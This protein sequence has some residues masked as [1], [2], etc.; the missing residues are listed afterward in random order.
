M[1][2][3]RNSRLIVALAILG[4]G[5]ATIGPLGPT[6]PVLAARTQANPGCNLIV[7]SITGDVSAFSVT[8]SGTLSLQI[9]SL[10]SSGMQSITVGSATNAT[11]VV[12]AFTVGTNDPVAVT[13]SKIDLSQ[14]ASFTLTARDVVGH[15]ITITGTVDCP[16]V[17]R[18]CTLTQGFWKTHPADWPVR[19]LTLGTVTY[20]QSQLL[21]ILRE[22]VRGNGLVSLAK[23]LIAA[24]LN[25]ASGASAPPSVATAITQADALIGAR[26]IP[27]V[28]AGFLSPDST[29][30]LTTILDNYNNGV[31]PGGP[32]HCD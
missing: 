8:G 22:P 25:I 12:A 3:Y 5:L 18:G 24:K 6:G 32:P 1:K 16:V 19:S 29:S 13:A 27:P 2:K 10:G 31:A 7:A 26:I 4:A 30:T 20:T 9:A 14:P 17:T 28:G 21:S 11:V 23:Q 15:S